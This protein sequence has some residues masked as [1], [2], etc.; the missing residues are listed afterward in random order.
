MSDAYLVITC[1]H[2]NE[3]TM[4][5]K[6]QIRCRI[7]RHAVYKNSNKPVDPHLSRQKCESLVKH[8]KVFGCCKPFRL[9]N[10]NVPEICD[11]I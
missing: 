4:I 8:K 2:C 9:N 10:E 7:F 6:K 1:P 11:Y 5:D 3:L